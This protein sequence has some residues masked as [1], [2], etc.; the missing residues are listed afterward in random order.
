MDE[1]LHAGGTRVDVLVF[2]MRV[3]DWVEADLLQGHYYLG[4]GLVAGRVLWV[5]QNILDLLEPRLYFPTLFLGVL[6]GDQG[7][8]LLELFELQACLLLGDLL[9]YI[10]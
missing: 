6:D 10:G 5:L 9:E 2:V 1:P 8:S 7:E 3:L 4:D